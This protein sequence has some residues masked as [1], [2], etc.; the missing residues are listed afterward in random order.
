MVRRYSALAGL[1]ILTPCT[2]LAA[3]HLEF[4]VGAGPAAITYAWAPGFSA[5]IGIGWK[6]FTWSIRGSTFLG[7]SW[8]DAPPGIPNDAARYHGGAIFQELRVHTDKIQS[9]QLFLTLGVGI[10]KLSDSGPT[11]DEEPLIIGNASHY[12]QATLGI[13]LF[14]SN[15]ASISLEAGANLWNGLTLRRAGSFAWDPVSNSSL[16]GGILQ[17]SGTVQAGPF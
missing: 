14:V 6:H 3:P 4:E 13:R 12:E 11:F 1:C 5:R 7:G 8:G 9:F 10:G 16:L 2:C 15:K 17:L